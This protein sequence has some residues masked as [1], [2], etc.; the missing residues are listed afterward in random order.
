M[1]KILLLALL[2]STV[3][4]SKLNAQCSIAQSSIK[5]SEV[6]SASNGTDC[7]VTFT[8][9]FDIAGNGGNKWS[10]IHIWNSSAAPSPA[11][12]WNSK[13]KPT[14]A[15]LQDG[16][17]STTA[18]L[19]KTISLDYSG[20]DPN[21][22]AVANN[23]PA[24][25]DVNPTVQSTGL[26]VTKNGGH[27]T[28]K[29]IKI[30][31]VNC[32]NE[33]DLITDVWS[34]QDQNGKNVACGTSGLSFVANDPVLRGQLQC[35]NPRSF[36][37]NIHTTET[38]SITYTA[39]FDVNKNAVIDATDTVP[40]NIVKDLSDV[41]YSNVVVEN[42]GSSD[43]T[44]FEN[45]GP[46]TFKTTGGH[47]IDPIIIVAQGEGVINR[48]LL[49][50]EYNTCI[51]LPVKF[52]SFNANRTSA[53][54]VSVTWTTAMEQNS[55]GFNVQ[56]N[57]GG[58][59]KTIAFV[60]SQADGG[61]SSSDLSYS[62]KDV[63]TEKGITQYRIQQ[64]DLD[65]NAKYSDIRAIRGESTSSKIVVYPNPSVDGKVN[66]VFEDNGVRDIQVNDMQ[67]RVVKSFKGITNNILVIEKLNSGFYTI[68]ITNR[69]TAA[70]SVEK[71]V[72]K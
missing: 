13:P 31:G 57:V 8:L 42:T 4:W 72:V 50:I 67:G 26:T 68:K 38:R 45:Y 53:S 60:F 33:L 37:L 36:T 10:F 55:R 16:A 12:D 52:K 40:A 17:G 22:V 28:I 6:I 71:V 62:F 3:A 32:A 63:N 7:D 56:K 39:Y 2:I 65:G 46:F 58:E 43:P 51:P 61:N 15:L 24:S 48:S 9:D 18:T 70:S 35:N 59:W 21:V 1:K 34:A 64:V 27:F 14:L 30:T 54:N 49:L 20:I 41:P 11:I 5:I 29:G 23:F 47:S 66:V 69:N 44:H 25:S 19:L